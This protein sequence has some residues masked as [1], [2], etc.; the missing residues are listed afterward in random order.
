MPTLFLQFHVCY[1]E[2]VFID[3]NVSLSYSLHK[4][5]DN[6][7]SVIFLLSYAIWLSF[8]SHINHSPNFAFFSLLAPISL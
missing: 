1:N 4:I 2:Y 6:M 5:K 8:A 7:F 3:T